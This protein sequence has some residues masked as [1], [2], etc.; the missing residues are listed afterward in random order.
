[1]SFNAR[2]CVCVCVIVCRGKGG[3]LHLQK[4]E[5]AGASGPNPETR[6]R[7]LVHRHLASHLATDGVLAL[8]SRVEYVEVCDVFCNVSI[9]QLLAED[10]K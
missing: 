5:K 8:H 6:M 2:V 9:F 7:D 10:G 3:G 4:A 1:M